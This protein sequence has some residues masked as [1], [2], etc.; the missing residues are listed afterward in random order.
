M[1][2]PRRFRRWRTLGRLGLIGLVAALSAA[3]LVSAPASAGPPVPVPTT[4]PTRPTFKPVPPTLSPPTVQP[5]PPPTP[6]PT[7]L[8]AYTIA[9]VGDSYT[10]GEGA[11]RN[12]IYWKAKPDGVDD[13][14]HISGLAPLHAAWAFLESGRYP[15]G[16]YT[17]DPTQ[18]RTT[19]GGDTF[20]FNASSGAKTKHL[21]QPQYENDDKPDPA[22]LRNAPQLQGIPA[23]TKIVYFGL[24]G[25]D[26]GFGS[27]LETAV[28]VYYEDGI[29]RP[30]SWVHNQMTAVRLEVGRLLKRMPQVSAN[31]EQGLVETHNVAQQADLVVAL[32]PLAI[33]QSGNGDIKQIAGPTLD[34]MYPFATEV[35]KAIKEA[36]DRFRAR[37]PNVNVHVFDPNTAGPNGSSVVA[38]HE[39]GQVEPYFTGLRPRYRLLGQFKLFKI[40][41]ES[42]HPNEVGAVTIGRALATWMAHE[43]P[44]LFPN[45]PDFSRVN[46]DAQASAD[47]P[48]ADQALEEWVSAHPEEACD[49]SDIDSICHFIGPDGEVTVPTEVLDNPIPLPPM[50]GAPVVGG[51]GGGSGGG[52]GPAPSTWIPA[53]YSSAPSIPVGGPIDNTPTGDPCEIKAKDPGEPGLQVSTSTLSGGGL[54]KPIDLVWVTF[55]PRTVRQDPC[56]KG[57]KVDPDKIREASE[58][59]LNTGT[60]PDDF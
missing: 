8:E 20:V 39:L 19:W 45:G 5:T 46:V 55:N 4:P 24:G 42:F 49:G 35:N 27:L 47:D 26:A 38:G 17:L 1:R 12:S 3:V 28:K 10:G 23:D 29:L 48:V 14:R 7:T 16:T 36:V 56:Q 44:A 25:N 43:F 53:T 21:T 11:S 32:Y 34:L 9:G 18:I 33:K 6:P 40:N 54:Q 2:L 51:G 52:G 13:W 41:Q 50:P 15:V 57:E 58:Q 37:Y 30:S 31:V 60:L 59:W 22:Q